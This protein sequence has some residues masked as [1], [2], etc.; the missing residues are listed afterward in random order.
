MAACSRAFS[1]GWGDVGAAGLHRDRR[2]RPRALVG[3]GVDAAGKAGHDDEPG[4]R[5]VGGEHG[6]KAH[7]VRGG[8][9]RPDDRHHPSTCRRKRAEAGEG[10][11]GVWQFGEGRGVGGLAAEDEPRADPPGLLHLAAGGALVGGQDGPARA[12]GKPGQG[13]QRGHGAAEPREEL[14]CGDGAYPPRAGQPQP[15]QAFGRGQGGRRVI[16]RAGT[17]LGRAACGPE[18]QRN[19]RSLL[20]DFR[21]IAR[22]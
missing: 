8:V 22:Q 16:A 19:S 20:A 17:R 10:D 1:A 13:L 11:R 5:E 15:R 9:A 21:F 4:G 14:A 2:A 12:G 3:G 18:L 6:G 7:P